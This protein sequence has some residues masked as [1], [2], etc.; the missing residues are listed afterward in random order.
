MGK[1]YIRLTKTNINF[2]LKQKLFYIASSSAHEVNLS[3]K[4]YASIY[5]AD[6]STLYMLDY[7]GSGNRTARDISEDGEITLLFNAFEG[8]PKILRCFCKGEV[9]AKEDER[10]GAAL[11][12]FTEDPQAIRQIFKLSIYAVETSCGMGVP[13]MRYQKERPEVRDFALM[14]AKEGRF[15][16]YADAHKIPPKLG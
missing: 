2:I 6:S 9:I 12:F 11:S 16:D 14:M 1:Q 5:V 15:D 4:G 8:K 7:L 3:P 13:L 10:F